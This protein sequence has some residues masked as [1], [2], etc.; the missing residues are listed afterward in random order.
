MEGSYNRF[1]Q[2]TGRFSEQNLKPMGLSGSLP[3]NE[4][5]TQPMSETIQMRRTQQN[6]G[7]YD[8]FAMAT[9]GGDTPVKG[10]AIH[11]DILDR[12]DSR[13][14]IEV[15][16]SSDG[17]VELSPDK[18]TSATV[19]MATDGPAIRHV[20]LSPE[21]LSNFGDFSFDGND[22]DLSS[23]P[24]VGISGIS[25]ST[26]SVYESDK[27]SRGSAEDAADAL[28][29]DSEGNESSDEQESPESESEAS[30]EIEVS[31]E[32]IGLTAE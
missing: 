8:A 3:S 26:E 16:L 15:E 14:Y 11:H 28:F 29:G 1:A 27:D 5:E 10:L 24:A 22:T 7:D 25:E 21:F 30:E 6:S 12:L 23:V 17:P 32:E 4:M 2:C 18:A 19:K 13:D 20:Y 31:D 9:V